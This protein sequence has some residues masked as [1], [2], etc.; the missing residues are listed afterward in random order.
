M[1]DRAGVDP[2][3]RGTILAFGENP[4]NEYWQT[5]QHILSRLPDL[6]WRVGYTTGIVSR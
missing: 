3:I 5:R 2:A 6:G 1:A 4:W